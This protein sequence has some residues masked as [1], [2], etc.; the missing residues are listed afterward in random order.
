MGRSASETA[1][2]GEAAFAD[3]VERH[4]L[5]ALDLPRTP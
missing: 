1:P 5:D 3:L 2:P 4:R